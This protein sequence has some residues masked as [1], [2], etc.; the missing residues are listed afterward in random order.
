MTTRLSPKV[1]LIGWDAADWRMIR[2]LIQAGLMPTLAGLIDRGASGN[3]ATIHPVL[4][5]ILWTSIATGKRADKHGIH[6]F[7][8]P[9]PDGSGIRPVNSTSRT[10][11]AIW[12]ILS[13]SGLRSNVVGWFA[14]HPAEPIQG[15]VVTDYYVHPA[16]L[17]GGAPAADMCHP[18]RLATPLANLRVDPADLDAEALLPFV[19]QAAKIDFA[20]DR[21][22]MELASLLARTSSIHAAACALLVNEPWDFMAV[23]YD[24]IDQ[25][26]HHFMPYHPPRMAGV[27]E[28]DAEI[29]QHVMTGCYRFHDMMLETLL[30][31]AGPDATVILAS[32]HGFQSGDRRQDVDGFK[33]PT[34]WHRQHGVV[35]VAGPGIERGAPLHGATLLDIVPTILTLFGLPIGADMDGRPWLEILDRQVRPD[36]IPSWDEAAGPCGS[37]APD[38]RADRVAAGAPIPHLGHP[39]SL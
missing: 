4:S 30:A 34:S 18:A 32:D 23:Y 9:Q 39:R 33:N 14:S 37:H 12:N 3:L 21:R 19:P 24:A 6:G 22:L 7:V 16:T 36:R 10:T 29:Y 28:L 2:P 38:R 11:K 26:G 15:A 1:L 17:R 27:S 8:E 13:Q 31:H 35:C 25:F 5:P 20:N